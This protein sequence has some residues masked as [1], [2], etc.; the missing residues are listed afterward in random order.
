MF[1]NIPLHLYKYRGGNDDIFL[2][3]VKSLEECFYWSASI[4]SLNDPCEAMINVDNYFKDLEGFEKVVHSLVGTKIQVDAIRNAT[5]QLLDKVLTTGVFSLSKNQNDELMWSHYG[6]AHHGFC[7]GY[8]IHYLK[9]SLKP[10]FHNLMEVRYESLPPEINLVDQML[11][12]NKDIALQQLIG[13]KSKKWENEEEIRIVSDSPGQQIHDFRAIDEVYFGLRM[14]DA[15]KEFMMAKLKGRGIK[16]YKME[17]L[18][19]AYKFAA[20]PLLDSFPDEPPY[21]YK[22][23]PVMDG[24]IDENSVQ[25]RFQHLTSYLEKA[26]EVARREPYCIEVIMVDFSYNCSEDAPCIFAH[27]NRTDYPYNNF[28]YSLNEIDILYASITDFD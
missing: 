19:G 15:Q 24:A 12:K 10:H 14:P 20:K 13:T 18:T 27:C 9:R 25:P 28:E 8:N 1:E 26:V 17:R 5:N 3:D 11:S 7:V 16:Y 22:V 21:L 2:R 4:P 6:A 23:A